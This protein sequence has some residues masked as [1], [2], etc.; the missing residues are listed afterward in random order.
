M[1]FLRD[2]GMRGAPQLPYSPDFTPSD[3]YLFR[4][5]KGCLSGFSFADADNSGAFDTP[6]GFSRVDGAAEK[7]Y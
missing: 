4:H 5:V 2:N 7:M 3:L 6:G 1:E